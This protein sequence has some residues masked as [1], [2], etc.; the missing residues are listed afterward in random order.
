MAQTRPLDQSHASGRPDERFDLLKSSIT[1]T[2]AVVDKLYL[3]AFVACTLIIIKLFTGV[4]D[5]V[6]FLGLKLKL[7]NP[8]PIA[9]IFTCCHYVLA[10]NLYNAL[11]EATTVLKS[12]QKKTILEEITYRSGFTIRGL[13]A[14]KSTIVNGKARIPMPVDDPTT[15][16]FYALPLLLTISFIDL[17]HGWIVLADNLIVCAA[18]CT[19]NWGI[20][21]VW[22]E[23]VSR[24]D[25][26]SR[27]RSFDLSYQDHLLQLNLVSGG[28][29]S[30]AIVQSPFI[31]LSIAFIFAYLVY[32]G[33]MIGSGFLLYV[34]VSFVVYAALAIAFL[35][36]V[37]SVVLSRI[38]LFRDKDFT[39]LL[40]II[41]CL[42][43]VTYLAWS[44][45][46]RLL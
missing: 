2:L 7:V 8:F 46:G 33:G 39:A 14:R 1:S 26:G 27:S 21:F 28:E 40:L 32:Y 11:S 3:A 44:G 43:G 38:K 34:F 25:A 35:P 18:F 15:L 22:V 36:L 20:G 9:L 16:I 10:F 23:S 24:L 17:R 41:T 31:H 29:I 12:V 30:A 4:G 6:S 5:E 42:Y 45:L 19:L 13:T 37:D